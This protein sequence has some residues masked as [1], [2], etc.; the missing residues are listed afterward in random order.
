MVLLKYLLEAAEVDLQEAVLLVHLQVA[1]VVLAVRTRGM[2]S[3]K[4]PC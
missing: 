3:R 4:H 1:S 2:K